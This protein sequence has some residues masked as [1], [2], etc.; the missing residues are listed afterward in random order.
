M[1]TT[2]GRRS[3]SVA[4]SLALA[5]P[6]A[7]MAGDANGQNALTYSAGQSISPAFEGWEPNA[8]GTFNMVFGYM[9]HNWDEEIDIP[10]GPNN[11]LEPGGPDQGQPTHF[12]PRR[13]RFV[14]RV[15]VPA[16]W[17]NKDLVWT[18]TVHGR[19]EQA[20]GRLKPEQIIDDDIISMN[21][22]GGGRNPSNKAPKVTLEGSDRRAITLGES[23]TLVAVVTDDGLPKPRPA[24]G[25]SPNGQNRPPG[26]YS[27]LGLRVAWIQYRGPGRITFD[28]EQFK[29]Y[30]DPRSGSP[31]SEGWSPPAIPSDG[32]TTVRA[33][34]TTPGTYVIRVIVHDGY[35]SDQK[36]VTITVNPSGTAQ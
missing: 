25:P 17:G 16:D 13:N 4:L 35:L 36:D 34:F 29:V 10:V 22:S 18:L 12:F 9:N 7:F 33:S 28:P 2:R 15:R 21:S 11:S 5:L 26:R 30:Q 1:G 27:S 23:V 14:F 20:H 6:L 8:D 3:W 32:K 24:P 31:W 19:T